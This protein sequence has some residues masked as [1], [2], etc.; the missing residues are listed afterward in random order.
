MSYSPRSALLPLLSLL[1]ALC[2]LSAPTALAATPPASAQPAASSTLFDKNNLAAWCIVPFDKAKRTPEQRAS[3]LEAI[4]LRKFVH[5]YRG[6]HVPFF[7]DEIVALKK[8]GIELLGWMFNAAA[9][10]GEPDR[11]N[12]ESERQ[13]ALF[14]KHGVQPQLWVIRGGGPAQLSSAEEQEKRVAA[15]AASL[16]TA[17]RIA[18]AKGLK[19]GLYNHGGW[20][21]EPENQVAIIERLRAEGI[22]N[23]GIVYNLHHGHNHLPRFS[24]LLQK[25]L[26]HLICLNLNGMDV[27][28]DQ[29]G[30]KILPIGAGTEDVQVLQTILQSGYRGPIGILNH[31][32][33]DAEQRLLDNLDGLAWIHSRIQG[34]TSATPPA[35]RSWKPTPPVAA[36]P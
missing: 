20:F 31:T 24:E 19:I 13:L 10:P 12:A 2:P 28:G 1:P 36:A 9:A 35:Y 23:V 5:D 3:M 16:R 29:H 17:A 22:Q 21:G 32:G 15:E 26:P 34:Q 25:M 7:E 14:E 6:E 8:H 18:A 4:G 30:R 33:E 11:L 27:H